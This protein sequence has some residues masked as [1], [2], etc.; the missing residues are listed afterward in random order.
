M[1]ASFPVLSRFSLLTFQGA[2]VLLRVAPW[3]PTLLL[4]LVATFERGSSFS[5]LL[6]GLL[7]QSIIIYR[8]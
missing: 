4:S 7:S 5:L 1:W 2:A 3:R 6:A 8:L